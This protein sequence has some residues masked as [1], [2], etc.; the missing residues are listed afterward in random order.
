MHSSWY[1]DDLNPLYVYEA[2]MSFLIRLAQTRTGAERLLEA[3]VLPVLSQSDYI[4]ATPEADQA[5]MG[6][7]SILI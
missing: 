7:Y 4:D 6:M 2:K 3:Q 1:T 5:F